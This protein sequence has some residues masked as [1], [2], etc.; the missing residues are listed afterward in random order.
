MVDEGQLLWTPA[1][2]FAE[3][4]NVA[5]FMRWLDAER[6]LAFDSYDALW[7]WSVDRVEDFWQA[8][9]DYFEL[10]SVSR[11]TS[12]LNSRSMPGAGWFEGT[13]VNYAQHVLRHE[14]SGDPGRPVL[15]HCSELRDLDS[16]SWGE[17]GNQVRVL[18]TEL[19]R[20]G[21]KR[22]DRV[23]A[24]MPNIPETVVAML[25]TVAIGAV[26]SAAAPE[27]GVE[28][29]VD[30][31]S[32][33]VPKLLFV[34]DGYRFGGK[35]FD[36][37]AQIADIAGAVV[38][39]ET[40]VVLNYLDSTASFPSSRADVI[41]WESL[42][43]RPAIDAASFQFDHVSSE[44][45]LWILFSSGTTGLPKAIVHNHTGILL[46]HYKSS[47][48]H[49]NLKPGSSMFFYSTTGWMMWNTLM[50]A[51]LMNGTSVL[52]DGHPA[53]PDPDCLWQLAAR[54]GACSFGTSPT[55]I[56]N[57]QKLD[58]VPKRNHDLSNLENVF[59]V[60][61]PAS[62]E[63]FK[64][65]Y[66]NVK[67]DLWVTS[68]S[69]GTEFCSGLVAGVPTLPV[70]AGE[71][72]A[73]ALGADV[74]ALDDQGKEV[75]DDV[76]EL[77]ITKPMPS[78]PIFLWGDSDGARY[79]ESYFD[80]YPDVWRHGDSIKIN[81]RG[82]CYVYG[83]SDATLNRFGVRIGSAEVY[84]TLE[85]IGNVSDSLIV[86]IEEK[87]GGYYMPLFVA[88]RE[89]VT[90]DDE[91]FREINGKLRRERSPRHVPDEIIVAPAIPYTLTGKKMEVPVRK[92]LMGAPIERALAKGA[93]KD[94][95]IIIWYA[96]FAASRLRKL[97]KQ[98]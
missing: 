5:S 67:S 35:D 31:F 49:L 84:R 15:H 90:L 53:H 11:A 61:S 70:F 97:E 34:T 4:S 46:E 74:H 57:M 71:I 68:Q 17:F 78:M 88:L 33:I 37:R 52:Y 93:M 77:V 18:A 50:W 54:T 22:G 2:S 85:T 59:L 24:Y 27:F 43:D 20:I 48:F 60:G 87:D 92:L 66:S 30:R 10:H 56:Q 39:I 73:R 86:C 64:W 63:T 81:R 32:Q 23:A 40:I 41:S 16:L 98:L 14:N 21:I 95:A 8:I 82:G 26:W 58:L 25:A 83:R 6:G 19:R 94:P 12:V 75:I 3:S 76:G 96:D 29:V 7:R 69:G 1:R 44:H 65:V 36:R 62:P 80:T 28:T 42:V 13:R 47:A 91:L 89:G 72:Q 45:P 55:F 9:W 38:S 79:R 51:P